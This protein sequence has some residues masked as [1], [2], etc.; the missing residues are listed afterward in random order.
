MPSKGIAMLRRALIGVAIF[1]LTSS[2]HAAEPAHAPAGTGT[3][4]YVSMEV[5]G[6]GG[7]GDDCGA[8]DDSSI[9]ANVGDHVHVCWFGQN[10]TTADLTVH[11]ISDSLDGDIFTDFDLDIPATQM[12]LLAD[13]RVTVKQS[14]DITNTWVARAGAGG[15]PITATAMTHIEALQP[16][17]ALDAP[18][19]NATAV[20]GEIVHT[21]L[22]LTNAGTGDLAW[23]FGEADM[24]GAS[25]SAP[26]RPDSAHA[27]KA[28]AG[29]ATVPAYA[30]Q[31]AG[32]GNHLVSLDMAA[33]DNPTVVPATLPGAISAG[34][35]VDDDFSQ[36]LLLS[37]TDGLIV[38]DA[39]TG[40]LNTINAATAPDAGDTGWLAMA[41]NP[42]DRTLYALSTNGTLPSLYSI[43]PATGATTRLG[44]I[45]DRTL[46]INGIYTALAADSDGRLFAIDETNDL[47][48]A[49][50][51]DE[52]SLDGRVSGYTVGPLGIDIDGL[53]ALAFDSATNTLFL[54]AVPVGGVGTMYSV[55]TV[56]GVATPIGTIGTGDSYLAMSAVVSARPCG[57]ANDV[58][59]ISLDTYI[60]PPLAAGA[61]QLVDVIFDATDLV[62]GEYDANLCLH[63][64]DATQRKVPI[65]VHLSVGANRDAIFGASF[66]GDVP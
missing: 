14:L 27:M 57:L 50:A 56:S 64:N 8:L 47:L 36:E 19:L 2:P 15:N 46:T 52:Y 24:P 54:S 1:L 31:I 66:E 38:V 18:S 28:P 22:T 21:T 39:T 13:F 11:S 35:F 37:D 23:H 61:S 16:T 44:E 5:I 60:E 65:P 62:P 32:G 45:N 42:L 25:P 53:S 49:V 51:R 12:Q 55:D 20:A 29:T 33:P 59:W 17:L 30:I 9:T 40:A 26:Q 7:R 41:W 63:T 43:D 6:L 58:A 3:I 10:N 34:A 4:L 48:V